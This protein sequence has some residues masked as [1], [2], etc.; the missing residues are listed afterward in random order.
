MHKLESI[1]DRIR[2]QFD[3][4]T[5]ARD[6]ALA[7]SRQLVRQCALAIRAVHREEIPTMNE[8]LEEARSLALT[9]GSDLAEHPDLYYAGYTQDALKEYVEAHVTCA[10]ILGQPLQEPEDL[11]V[12]DA[13][14]LNGLAETVGELR[15]R[16]MDILR[17]GHSDEA[18]RLLGYMDE[19]Y[20]VLVTIDYPDAITDGL[21]RKTDIARGI[22]ERTRGDMTFSLRSANLEEAI[23]RFEKGIAK[24]E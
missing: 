10:L 8:H 19:I 7:Q 22:I 20:A 17:H 6:Q 23:S 14:Y 13:T 21:R 12:P 11:D 9:L 16:I 2:Q 1:A 15:R 24:E 5:A 3:A 18:E 4:R